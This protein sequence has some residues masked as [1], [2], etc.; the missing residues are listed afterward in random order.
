MGS[1]E[2]RAEKTLWALRPLIAT[3]SLLPMALLSP[4]QAHTK[5]DVELTFNCKLKAMMDF[6]TNVWSPAGDTYSII[7]RL[8]PAEASEGVVM[9]EANVPL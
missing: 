4:S 3:A 5:P 6:K 1:T 8:K 2:R 9:M 7:V